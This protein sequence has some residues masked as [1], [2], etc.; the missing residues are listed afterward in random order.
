MNPN[1]H[2]RNYPRAVPQYN[3]GLYLIRIQLNARAPF[4]I[5]FFTFAFPTVTFGA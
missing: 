1:H 5:S 4:P 3:P 2:P